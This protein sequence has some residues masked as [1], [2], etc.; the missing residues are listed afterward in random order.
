LGPAEAGSSPV[1]NATAGN[2]TTGEAAGNPPG[3][4]AADADVSVNI[5]IAPA[6]KARLTREAPLFVF[7]REPGGKGP[8]LAA[9]RLTSA[10]IGTQIHLSAADSMI[11]GRTLTKGSRVSITARVSFSGQPLPAAGDLYGELTYDVGQDG[12]RDLLIDRVAD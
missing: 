9:K 6:I 4:A 1:R 3:Q 8:P 10:A 5:R 11:P 7:A 12:T 2:A